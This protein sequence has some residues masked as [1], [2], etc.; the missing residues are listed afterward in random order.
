MLGVDFADTGLRMLED[1]GLIIND[2]DVVFVQGQKHLT[3]PPSTGQ[4]DQVGSNHGRGSY[5]GK[6]ARGN[7]RQRP[8]CPWA[9]EKSS[10]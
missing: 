4:V 6:A 8:P 10:N 1:F 7:G 9:T 2:V 5:Y 3:S